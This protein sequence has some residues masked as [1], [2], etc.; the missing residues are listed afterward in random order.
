M[1]EF[2]QSRSVCSGLFRSH[3]VQVMFP[4]RAALKMSPKPQRVQKFFCT[5]CGQ[6]LAV[7]AGLEGQ[8]FSCPNCA[9]RGH[10]PGAPPRDD[11]GKECL[12][13]FHCTHCGQ[14]LSAPDWAVGRMIDCPL[15]SEKTTVRDEL[16]VPGTSNRT[17][18]APPAGGS[19]PGIGEI[20]P[21]VAASSSS[22]P[23][24]DAETSG[25]GEDAPDRSFPFAELGGAGSA[26]GG[27]ALPEGV[28]RHEGVGSPPEGRQEPGKAGAA[29]DPRTGSP[30][31]A[32]GPRATDGGGR[33]NAEGGAESEAGKDGDA[34]LRSLLALGFT[35]EK[36]SREQGGEQAP[37]DG[38]PAHKGY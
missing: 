36:W 3:L 10:V 19:T 27:N 13:R 32:A 12:L 16:K 18:P 14:K 38:K 29:S 26:S 7:P 5:S 25:V 24:P 30:G 23:R 33:E 6:K 37:V 9:A 1:G 8:G 4:E 21:S 34:L 17:S 20:V 15:C 2:R 11:P 28:G 31:P 22:V 35:V